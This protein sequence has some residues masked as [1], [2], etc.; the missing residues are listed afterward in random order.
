M[1]LSKEEMLRFA[2][3]DNIRLCAS[4]VKGKHAVI[5][6]Q[7]H[8]NAERT[9]QRQPPAYARFGRI[10]F[11]ITATLLTGSIVLQ[12]FFAG[13]GLMVDG[14]QMGLHRA[15]GGLIGLFP[16]VLLVLGL[17]GRVPGRVFGLVGLLY[18]LYVLQWVFVTVPDLPTM[19]ALHPVNA[20]LLFLVALQITRGAWRLQRSP[21][22]TAR[23]RDRE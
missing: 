19:R 22:R 11:A 17:I 21:R 12:V 18:L 8:I 14:D 20:L 9:D 7:H 3:H 10:A 15:M 16:M 5:A 2:Q 23:L 1:Y 4:K 6:A 13:L